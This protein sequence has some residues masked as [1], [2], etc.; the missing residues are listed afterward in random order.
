MSWVGNSTQT[1]ASGSI[2]AERTLP[3]AP[4]LICLAVEYF[5][6]SYIHTQLA[7]FQE[8]ALPHSHCCFFVCLFVLLIHILE[9][10]VTK[11]MSNITRF[12]SWKKLFQITCWAANRSNLNLHEKGWQKSRRKITFKTLNS[13]EDKD[14]PDA[15]RGVQKEKRKITRR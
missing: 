11:A 8:S 9:Y 7:A 2:H 6:V 10:W 5:Q 12:K 3:C 14:L 15:W 4:E 13:A 1:S